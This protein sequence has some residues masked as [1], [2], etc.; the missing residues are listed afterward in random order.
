MGA[1]LSISSGRVTK[2]PK[3]FLSKTSIETHS[4]A[5]S[6]LTFLDDSRASPSTSSSCASPSS[7]SSD[8]SS[9]CEGANDAV[10]YEF[11]VCSGISCNFKFCVKCNCKY[12][13]RQLCKDFSPASPT[14]GHM[15]KSSVACS[16][17]SFKSLKRLVY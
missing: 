9:G 4:P 10:T 12:H 13:P 17:Q 1:I 2:R 3:T 5:D 14:R 8:D 11:G 16:S 15:N 6:F 7:F